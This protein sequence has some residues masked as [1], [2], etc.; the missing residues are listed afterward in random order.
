MRYCLVFGASVN[1]EKRPP[2]YRAARLVRVI[3]LRIPGSVFEL[4]LKLLHDHIE[5]RFL[6]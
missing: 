4:E 3:T 5:L 6:Y 1:A 2:F